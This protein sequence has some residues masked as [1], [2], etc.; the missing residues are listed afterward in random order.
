MNGIW[1]TGQIALC[2]L[3]VSAPEIAFADFTNRVLQSAHDTLGPPWQGTQ[4]I[5]SGSNGD[6]LDFN[7]DYAVWA[8]GNFTSIGGGNFVPFAG[9]AGLDP[10]DY[11]YAYQVYDNGPGHGLSNRSFSQ[12]GLCS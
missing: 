6:V 9:F 3:A 11:V 7:V 8:P 4:N 1:R 10:N 2:V 12:L 5:Y